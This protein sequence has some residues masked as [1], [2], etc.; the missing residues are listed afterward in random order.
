MNTTPPD[1]HL[2]TALRHAPDADVAAPEHVSA[3]ILAAAHRSAAERPA[4]APVQRTWW[5]WAPAQRWG[6]SGALATVLMAGV[7]GLLW[8]GDPPGPARDPV[9]PPAAAPVAETASVAVPVTA[10]PAVVTRTEPAAR[11]AAAKARARAPEATNQAAAEPVATAAAAAAAAA[12]AADSAAPAPP[13]ASPPIAAAARPARAAAMTLA[14]SE[15]VTAPAGAPWQANLLQGDDLSWR[16]AE[17]L[18]APD[19]LWLARL[20]DRTRGRWQ[21]ASAEAAAGA[22]QLQWQRDGVLIGRWWI[23]ADA[24]LWCGAGTPCQ[25]A[26]VDL[27]TLQSLLSEL[28]R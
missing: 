6:A 22:R 12:P 5:S 11:P 8:H 4:Q 19:A 3:Q 7:L 13:P 28:A 14:H 9:D 26:A 23:E 15:G 21:P 16:P 18:R 2:R 1:P 17:G 27:Q 25:R 24:V 10:P 20:A